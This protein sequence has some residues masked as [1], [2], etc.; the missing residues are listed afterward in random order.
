M[1]LP[2]DP[3]VVSAQMHARSQ[4]PLLTLQNGLADGVGS[5]GAGSSPGHEQPVQSQP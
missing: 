1:V 3:V 2:H 4:L 5:S